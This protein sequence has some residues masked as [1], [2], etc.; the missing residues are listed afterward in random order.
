MKSRNLEM[1]PCKG[2]C[3][4]ANNAGKIMLLSLLYN[5]YIIILL[6]S[7]ISNIRGCLKP[8]I[9]IFQTKRG[10]CLQRRVCSEFLNHISLTLPC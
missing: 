4:R 1:L 8:C 2:K 9:V 5:S 7:C 3:N 6:L 10:L